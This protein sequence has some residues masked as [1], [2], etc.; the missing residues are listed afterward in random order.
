MHS[1]YFAGRDFRCANFSP[2]NG[3]ISGWGYLD[4]WA[5]TPLT[6]ANASAAFAKLLPA[7]AIVPRREGA[8]CPEI[9]TG[10]S[11]PYSVC[12]AEYRRGGRWHLAEGQANKTSLLPTSTI[13]H[14]STWT[15]RWT[16]CSLRGWALP[17][18][19][20][21]NNNCGKGAPQSD[22]Y[23]V[24]QEMWWGPKPS[25]HL[26]NTRSAGWQFTDSAG[27]GSIGTYRCARRGRSVTC[28]TRLGDS[29]RYTP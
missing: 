14:T 3:Y 16:R 27:F 9:L 1:P 22:A 28:T 8:F 4:G 18:A 12:F 23:F 7:G 17:G 21:S 26:G 13:H 10:Q 11:K 19:L 20:Y 24:Y 15:R 29:F 25:G 2:H 5:P 6:R